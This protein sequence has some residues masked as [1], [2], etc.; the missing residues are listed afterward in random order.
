M[1]GSE[2]RKRREERKKT[3]H[4]MIGPCFFVF[5]ADRESKTAWIQIGIAPHQIWRSG[6]GGAINYNRYDMYAA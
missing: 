5:F 2:E 4:L 6:A 3:T 1:N